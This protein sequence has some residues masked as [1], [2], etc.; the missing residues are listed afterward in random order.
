MNLDEQGTY[1]DVVIDRGCPYL[2]APFQWTDGDGNP[3]G[4]GGTGNPIPLV[5]YTAICV[6]RT[7]NGGTLL[8]ELTQAT[9]G[10]ITLSQ[11]TDITDPNCG[12]YRFALTLAQVE[13][14]PLGKI[15]MDLLIIDPDGNPL[16]A[17]FSRPFV[18]NTQSDTN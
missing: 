4:L 9:G 10:G 14:L 18:R 15:W 11:I 17:I 13:M 16:K 1:V 6:F 5:N 3:L 8:V 2:S 7:T 12:L